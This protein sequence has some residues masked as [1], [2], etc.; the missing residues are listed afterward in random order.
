[1]DV[2]HKGSSLEGEVFF[3]LCK[4]IDSPVSLGAWLRFKHNQLA[5]AEMEINP[6]DYL[7]SDSFAADYLVVSFLSKWKGLDTGL[8]LASEAMKR[9]ISSEVQCAESN[10]RI[11]EFRKAGDRK[12]VV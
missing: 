1:M 9:L 8:D 4:S 3:A 12:S 6:G 5:L 11:R 2:K 10:R 7:D